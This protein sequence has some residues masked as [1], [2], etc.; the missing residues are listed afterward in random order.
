MRKNTSNDL[1]FWVLGR[2]FK[3]FRVWGI[4]FGSLG[5]GYLGLRFRI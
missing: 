1:G 4:G 5:L 3:V 2:G